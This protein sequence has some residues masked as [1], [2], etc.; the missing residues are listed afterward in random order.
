M[1]KDDPLDKTISVGAEV[2]ATGVKAN[3]KSRAVAAF[4]R[5]LGNVVDF[6]NIPIERRN[7]E[8]RTKI[9]GK[10]QLVEAVRDHALARMKTDPEFADRAVRAFLDSLIAKQENKDEVV[11]Q[12]LEDLRRDP[13]SE[14]D[15]P[16]LD[17]AFMNKLER[18]AED[19]STEQLREKWGR[20]LAAEIRKPGTI[21]PRAMR[22]VD[23]LDPETAQ[24][25]EKLCAS[26]LENVVPIDLA[27]PLDYAAA[28]KLVGAGLLVEPAQVGQICPFSEM[29]A[30]N[31][32]KV[33]FVGFGKRGFSI[34]RGGLQRSDNP[35]GGGVPFVNAPNGFPGM[36]VYLLTDEGYAV[37]RILPDEQQRA[38][39]QYLVDLRTRAAPG[40]ITV[41][42]RDDVN[43]Q[44]RA[45]QQADVR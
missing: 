27:G 40:Q 24:L 44:W 11:R 22:I 35:S 26:R 13:H 36:R 9:E 43:S 31:G 3:A 45:E 19:A 16:E 6:V 17:P 41:Y 7:V 5:L 8:E 38:F 14:G 18:H 15:A 4:D 25:F 21:S 28:I 10:R 30:P 33:A 29:L 32:T 39:E 1:G 12:A 23:E 37:S 2:T 42:R 20:V 34:P